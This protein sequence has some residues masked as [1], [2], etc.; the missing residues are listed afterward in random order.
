MGGVYVV[1][2]LVIEDKRDKVAV[3]IKRDLKHMEK[4]NIRLTRWLHFRLTTSKK[5]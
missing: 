5:F 3:Q 2:C 4:H 1:F